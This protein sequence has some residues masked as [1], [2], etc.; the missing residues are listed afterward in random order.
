M[1]GEASAFPWDVMDEALE[2]EEGLAAVLGELQPENKKRAVATISA[3]Q[4]PVVSRVLFL[5][6]MVLRLTTLVLNI[7]LPLARLVA[8]LFNQ[9]GPT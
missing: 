2:C 1:V 4:R 8:Y 5:A 3:A 6:S 9:V 7:L